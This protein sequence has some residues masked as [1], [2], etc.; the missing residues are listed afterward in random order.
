MARSVVAEVEA[1][2]GQPF[3]EVVRG[4]AS[5]NYACATTARILGYK[6][7]KGLQ[8]YLERRGVKIDWPKLGSCN[9]H[10]SRAP[11][12]DETRAKL[13]A[14]RFKISDSLAKKYEE[15]TGESAFSLIDR[16]SRTHTVTQVSAILGYS[17]PTPFRAWMKRHGISAKFKS[18]PSKPPV[19]LG[20]QSKRCRMETDI[21][22][23][24]RFA[25]HG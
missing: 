18:S 6:H 16:L 3:I 7:P 8:T 2:Y 4:F 5:D 13:S 21:S 14:I 24:S 19:G 12:T 20:L 11:V 9:A 17:H 15:R 23:S 1:E 25:S 10:K 22:F